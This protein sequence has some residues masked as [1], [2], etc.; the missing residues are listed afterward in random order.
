MIAIIWSKN[1]KIWDKI[2][3]LRFL[4]GHIRSQFDLSV[5]ISSS[6]ASL[7]LTNREILSK[8]HLLLAKQKRHPNCIAYLSQF[9][10]VSPLRCIFVFSIIS[11]VLECLE[12]EF[13]WASDE[14]LQT[15]SNVEGNLFVSQK[16]NYCCVWAAGDPCTGDANSRWRPID[17]VFYV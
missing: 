16:S 17:D 10:Y 2:T 14:L 15:C 1:K 4:E 8:T 9:M 5:S 7:Q 12:L 6:V 3:H 11:N 13:C